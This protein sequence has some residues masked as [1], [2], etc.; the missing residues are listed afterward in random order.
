MNILSICGGGVRGIMPLNILK[1]IY[2]N[3]KIPIHKLFNFFCG[4][5]VGSIIICGI[6]VSDD[7]QNPLYDID[8]IFQKIEYLCKN[9]FERSLL[10]KTT[11][12]FGFNKS[13][14]PSDNLERE[15]I[16]LF[17]ERKLNSLLS[18][19]CFPAFDLIKNKSFYFN[20]NDHGEILIKDVLLAT[21]AAPYYFPSKKIKINNIDYDLCD[22]GITVN[23]PAELA[24]LCAT[25]D[26]NI[27]CKDNIYE[28]VLGTGF[29][30][31]KE[32]YN[33][34]LFWIFNNL[35]DYLF[36]GYND[37]EMYELDNSLQKDNYLYID[38]IIDDKYFVLDNNKKETIQYLLDI[39]N[40]WINNNEYKFKIFLDKLKSNN[41]II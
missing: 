41:I 29:S 3:F 4:S 16:N 6:L 31:I 24:Y 12:L 18:N 5:S 26:M 22:S 15:L 14:Y 38:Y 17:G 11:S 33:S 20:K 25:K 13:K 37:N 21:T 19:F 23:N 7:N 40:K 32:P 1:K 28:L 10:Y 35:I 30:Y 36:K 27:I 9:I 39:S 34:G 8:I 2:D